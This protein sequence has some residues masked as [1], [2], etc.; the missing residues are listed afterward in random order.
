MVW[1]CAAFS[2]GAHPI[3][4]SHAV[5]NVRGD[6]VLLE[7]KI[8]LEDLVLFHALKADAKTI[9]NAGDLRKAAE[10][11]D[12]FLLKHFTIRDGEGR[13]L[14]G[15]VDRRDI[16]AIP[17]DGVAQVELMKRTVIYLMHFTPAK[18]KPKF[19][20][21]TILH[22]QNTHT[23]HFHYSRNVVGYL[24]LMPIRHILHGCPYQRHRIWSTLSRAPR[25][26]CPAQ[27]RGHRDTPHT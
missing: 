16:N 4:M 22:I 14:E 26:T 1:L 25:P 10:K 2:A 23:T 15:K 27:G 6:E 7:L 24:T 20:T 11:H 19:L 17:D 18:K 3:S 12:E 8:M 9:F 21:F 13:L 5:A